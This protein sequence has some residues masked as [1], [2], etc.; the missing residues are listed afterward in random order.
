[1]SKRSRRKQSHRRRSMVNKL[2]QLMTYS[3]PFEV[4]MSLPNRCH[5]HYGTGFLT[6]IEIDLQHNVGKLSITVLEG[7][8]DKQYPAPDVVSISK[9]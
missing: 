4:N 2:V 9:G 1:M 8:V 5:V 3:I 7:D 6:N